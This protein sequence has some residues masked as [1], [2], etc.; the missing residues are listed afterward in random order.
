MSETFEKSQ[1]SEFFDVA[2][3][4][5]KVWRHSENVVKQSENA[6]KCYKNW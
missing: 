4:L 3:G 2:S 1:M 6:I 5:R